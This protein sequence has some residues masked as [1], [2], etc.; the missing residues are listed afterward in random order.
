[1]LG[2]QKKIG[3]FGGTFDPI[4]TGHLRAAQEVREILNLDKVSFVPSGRPPHKN[5]AHVTSPEDRYEMVQLAVREFPSFDVVDYE[6]RKE[7]I[8]YTIDTLIYLRSVEPEAEFYFIL[9]NELFSSIES[10]KNY[11]ELF[12]ISNFAVITRPGFENLSPRSLPLAIEDKF[13]YYKQTGN[14]T[15]YK[16]SACKLVALIEIQG[17]E[18]SSTEIRKRVRLGGSISNL[19]PK[20]IEEYIMAKNLYLQEAPQ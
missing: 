19:T 9:G 3:L 7:G 4:H 1:M 20:E 2:K 10:W 16:N 6:I 15:L 14:A 18:V 5:I 11:R 12:Q 13:L 8:S 17:V